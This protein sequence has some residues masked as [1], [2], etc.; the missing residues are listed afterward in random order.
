MRGRHRTTGRT[1]PIQRYALF[2]LVGIASE[3]DQGCN[4]SAQTAPGVAAA[5]SKTRARHRITGGLPR[6]REFVTLNDAAGYIVKLKKAEQKLEEWQTATE[7]LMMAAEDRGPLMHAPI[8]MLWAI[9]RNVERVFNPD[10]KD[11]HWG[12]RKLKRDE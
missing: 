1:E 5:I 12:K 6:G 3:D 9:N 10:R 2:T 11:A 4:R 7:V 8:G